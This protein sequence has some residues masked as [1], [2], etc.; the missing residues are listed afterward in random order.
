MPA[1]LTVQVL[2]QQFL[3]NPS[4]SLFQLQRLYCDE[5][6]CNYL[7]LWFALLIVIISVPNEEGYE[8]AACPKFNCRFLPSQY[9]ALSISI[10]LNRFHRVV[11]LEQRVAFENKSNF[12]F[13]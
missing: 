2:V 1:L 9:Q 12:N 6:A 11:Y 7:Y 13:A 4:L 3:I 10:F 8:I 5:P